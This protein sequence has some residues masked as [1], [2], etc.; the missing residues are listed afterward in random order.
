[1]KIEGYVFAFIAVFLV[2]DHDHL[3]G[4]VAA[5]RP[6]TTCLAL[7]IGLT[8]HDRLLPAVHG[9]PHGGPTRGPAGRRD[10]RGL[11]RDR[12]LPAALLVA[13]RHGGRRS[14]CMIGT[15]IGPFLALIGGGSAASSR[16]SGCCSSTTSASTARQGQTLGALQAMGERPTSVHKFLGD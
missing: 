5:T 8:V 3:L 9:P 15:V 16:C 14:P 7:S 2:P 13:D 12:L 4:A 6:G 11:R 1:M 10:Q